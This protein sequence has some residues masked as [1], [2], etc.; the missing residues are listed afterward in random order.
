[1]ANSG[2]NPNGS[3]FFLVVGDGGQEL[4]SSAYS[5]FGQITSGLDVA[6]EINAGGASSGTP[7]TVYKIDS[8]SVTA[9]PAS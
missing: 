6:N 2:A 9:S 1:M 7:K 3:Q 5:V 8:V 4:S